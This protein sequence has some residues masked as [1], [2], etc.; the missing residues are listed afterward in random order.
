MESGGQE[1]DWGSKAVTG[2]AG[3]RSRHEKAVSMD[4]ARI[5]FGS[6]TAQTCKNNLSYEGRLPRTASPPDTSLCL[7]FISTLHKRNI[8]VLRAK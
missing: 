7:K 8:S 1:R 4:V 5:H 6:F 2:S 3:T